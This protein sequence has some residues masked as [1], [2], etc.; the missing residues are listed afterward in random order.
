MKNKKV[1][2]ATLFGLCM[3][4]GASMTSLADSRKVV[5]LGANLSDS[6]RTM[7]LNYF[8]VN[9]KDRKSVV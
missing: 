8:G 5:T 1:I 7:M 9:E 4:M 2:G 6:Q 3:I